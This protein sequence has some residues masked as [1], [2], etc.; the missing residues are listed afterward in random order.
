MTRLFMVAKVLARVLLVRRRRAKQCFEG[1]NKMGKPDEC[2][3][4]AVWWEHKPL[5]I[6]CE[7]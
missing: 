1:Q 3:F 5:E 2:L 6:I 7:P 4:R